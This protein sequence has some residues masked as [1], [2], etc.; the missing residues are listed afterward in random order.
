M[1]YG[2]ATYAD[3]NLVIIELDDSDFDLY[4]YDEEKDEYQFEGDTYDS[5]H[6]ILDILLERKSIK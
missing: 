4:S 2:K 1:I 6:E 5:D 3:A